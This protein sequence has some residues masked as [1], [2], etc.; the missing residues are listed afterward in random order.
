[1]MGASVALVACAPDRAVM[2]T[3]VPQP[4]LAVS[5]E[6]ADRVAFLDRVSRTVIGMVPTAS[7]P[8]DMHLSPDGRDLLVACAGGQVDRIGLDDRTVR[9]SLALGF[10]PQSFVV[11]D[12]RLYVID[13]DTDD[14][15]AIDLADYRP[16]WRTPVGAAAEGLTISADGHRLFATA[17]ADGTVHEVDAASG[18]SVAQVA[19][20]A[21]PRRAVRARDGRIWVSAA[22]GGTVHVIDPVT[23]RVEVTLSVAPEGLTAEDANPVGITFNPDGT[24]ALVALGRA[25]QVA[26]IDVRTLAVLRFIPVGERP[27]SAAIDRTGAFAYV[28]NGRSN[29]VTVLDLDRLRPITDIAVGDGP[30]TILATG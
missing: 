29:D 3:D 15:V 9:R 8:R 10:T 20:G 27:W 17:E 28:A 19:V 12:G 11:R 26:V 22:A 4:P 7:G 6:R 25:G 13:G 1:M 14:L 21:G 24:R 18:A 2:P 5:L 23:D 30:H 16:L